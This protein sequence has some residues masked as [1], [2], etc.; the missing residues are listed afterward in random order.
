M[1]EALWGSSSPLDPAAAL[2]PTTPGW[3][4]PAGYYLDEAVFAAELATVFRDGWL[5]AGHSCELEETGDYLLFALGEESVVVVRDEAGELRAHHKTSA[6]TADPGSA[7]SRA[8]RCG[9][10]PVPTTSGPTG[11]TGSCA[12]PG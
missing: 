4:L 9:C 1:S 10:C 7:P 3:T 2:P 6:G 8:A 11:S 12:Q 5:F